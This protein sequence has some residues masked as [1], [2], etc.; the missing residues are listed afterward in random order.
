MKHGKPLIEV[1]EEA[2]LLD[3]VAPVILGVTDREPSHQ[4]RFANGADSP[5][6]GIGPHSVG[7][8]CINRDK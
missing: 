5:T 1:L 2:G 7:Q 6:G 4:G 8:I 3:D